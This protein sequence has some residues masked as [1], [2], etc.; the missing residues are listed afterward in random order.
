MVDGFPLMGNRGPGGVLMKRCS[1]ASADPT[2]CVYDCGGYYGVLS[3]D[4]FMY[5][6]YMLGPDASSLSNPITPAATS[7][8]FPFSPMCLLGCGSLSICRSLACYQEGSR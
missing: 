8:Y 4:S 1:Q 6:Y 2:Y 3:T 5:R 7:E